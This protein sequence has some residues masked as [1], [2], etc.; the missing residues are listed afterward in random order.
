MDNSSSSACIATVFVPVKMWDSSNKKKDISFKLDTG[1]Q[2][3]VIPHEVW[4]RLNCKVPVRKTT[5]K[6]TSYSG[7][8]LEVKGVCKMDIK[9]QQLQC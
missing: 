7:D 9:V 8:A 1:A 5:T 6:L 3:N 4:K 2:V